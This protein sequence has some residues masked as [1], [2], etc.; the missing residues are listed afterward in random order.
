MADDYIQLNTD[1]AGKKVRTQT[2]TVNS[3]T[4]H[5][6]YV[7]NTDATTG[8]SARVLNAIPASTDYGI[9][10]RRVDPPRTQRTFYA[11]AVAA[12]TTEGLITLSNVLGFATATTGTSHAITSGKTFRIQSIFAGHRMS[13][14]AAHYSRISLRVNPTGAVTTSSPIIAIGLLPA[15]AALA[16]TGHL[17]SIPIPD[18][19]DV[20]VGSGAQIGVSQISS[21]A[22][23]LI[24]VVIQGYE[25]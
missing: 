6:S 20:P 14:A 21:L 25:Y 13:T 5:E 2:R 12:T 4:V 18:G 8:N 16:Q 9:V 22:G 10:V 11:T 1:G 19:L 7:I 23:T 17:T 15:T 24:D 3:Q